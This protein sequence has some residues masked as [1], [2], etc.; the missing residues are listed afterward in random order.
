MSI[1][2]TRAAPVRTGVL[3]SAADLAEAEA[4][5]DAE[6]LTDDA[7]AADDLAPEA[8]ADAEPEAEGWRAADEGAGA[9]V[10]RTAGAG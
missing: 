4:D 5:A 2:N 10:G 7:E 8:E 9:C 3:M 1:A 6:G